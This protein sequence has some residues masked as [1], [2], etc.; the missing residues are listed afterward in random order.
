MYCVRTSVLFLLDSYQFLSGKRYQDD[1]KTG[2][3]DEK[4]A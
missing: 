2:V 1:T 4:N 3:I